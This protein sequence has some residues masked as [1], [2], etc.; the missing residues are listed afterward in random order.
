[1]KKLFSMV[2]LLLLGL[3]ISQAQSID[4]EAISILTGNTG[5][6]SQPTGA[7]LA[8]KNTYQQISEW[9]LEFTI[10]SGVSRNTMNYNNA[11]MF[12]QGDSWMTFGPLA[13][14][15][16]FFTMLTDADGSDQNFHYAECEVR[17]YSSNR[18]Q[19]GNEEIFSVSNDTPAYGAQFCN[20]SEFVP[21]NGYVRIK[22]VANSYL[23]FYIDGISGTGTPLPVE[24]T[25]FRSFVKDDQVVLQWNTATEL[26]NFG[27]NVERSTDGDTWSSLGFVAGFGTSSSPKQY[28][29]LDEQLD[30][31]SGTLYYRL[32]QVD[33][34]GTT[35]Y[36]DIL[37]V[38]LAAPN[39]V[40]LNAYPQPFASN[41]N[42]DLASKDGEQVT[43]TLYNSAMQ[44]VAAVYEGPLDGSLSLTVP[45]ESMR[46]GGYF[47]IVNHANGQT[48]V[49]KLMRMQGR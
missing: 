14:G 16:F 9:D 22:L 44:K 45:T 26:N 27:F 3:S 37:R 15:S 10:N 41:L 48:Q 40:Q 13:E 28:S 36:S 18:T 24:L 49:Q 1:M 23:K 38:A 35:D 5:S 46:N 19:V 47:L 8:L 6:F 33:R 42:I 7:G 32:K 4:F 31:S 34:D 17:V 43:V 12:D 39:S 25:S 21:A 20:V 11:L 29:F 2:A 30:R